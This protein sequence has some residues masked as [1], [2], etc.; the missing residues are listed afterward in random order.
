LE[1]YFAGDCAPA[2][3]RDIER[4]MSTRADGRAF[5]EA[6]RLAWGQTGR[7]AHVP[8]YD[9]DREW[10]R[11]A[12]RSI[13]Q[14]ELARAETMATPTPSRRSLPAV[15]RTVRRWV[16]PM[17]IGAAVMVGV[18]RAWPAVQRNIAPTGHA[19][20]AGVRE[21]ATAKGQIASLTLSDGTQVTL[22]VASRLRIP[23]DFGTNNRT[24]LLDG[25]AFFTVAQHT[26]K[27]FIVQT[28]T[29]SARVL[30]TAFTVRHYAAEPTTNV[31]VLTGRVALNDAV[32]AAG[33]RGTRAANG[34]V[35]VRHVEGTDATAWVAGKIVFQDAPMRD[36]V[37]ELNRWYDVQFVLDDPTLAA[38]P[39][40]VGFAG[41]SAEE[42]AGVLDG[43][44]GTT[45]RRT[46][47]QIT[48]SR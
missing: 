16:V 3:L 9:V 27:P 35:T 28:A 19:A 4:W 39:V 45:H 20:P 21:L 1:R 6:M 24:L 23:T 43:I 40:T 2:E 22:G 18:Y 7:P 14:P 5:V 29:A 47:T 32:V 8:V 30:G 13:E 10:Q 17:A 42:V 26:D 44:L 37:T 31:T 11:L 34:D 41:R 38:E 25:E 46:A 36:V 33:Q 15:A 12:A 48:L